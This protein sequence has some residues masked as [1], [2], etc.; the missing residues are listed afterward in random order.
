MRMAKENIL[1]PIRCSPLATMR[2]CTIWGS[3]QHSQQYMYML[4]LYH[5]EEP[6]LRPSDI[7]SFLLMCRTLYHGSTLQLRPHY[8]GL[9][10]YRLPTWR[11][12]EV[13]HN[14]SLSRDPEN[15]DKT[16]VE[17]VVLARGQ[18]PT[19][20]PMTW[21]WLAW[22]Y[23]QHTINMGSHYT[24]PSVHIPRLLSVPYHLCVLAS[25]SSIPALTQPVLCIRAH[26][27]WYQWEERSIYSFL[28]TSP[29]IPNIVLAPKS[30]CRSGYCGVSRSEEAW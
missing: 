3:T 25:S 21:Y 8:L 13:S 18:P 10:V 14:S 11:G 27:I 23:R 28:K 16:K 20:W 19:F 29:A 4:G 24:N 12:L 26:A 6:R 2:T 22:S 15:V 9:T 5:L 7:P 17:T 1:F 30:Q